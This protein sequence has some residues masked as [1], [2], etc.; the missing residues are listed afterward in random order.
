MP[1][2]LFLCKTHNYG[3][4]ILK[5]IK[6]IF[7][8]R[9]FFLSVSIL[10]ALAVFL[11]FI[12]LCVN[13]ESQTGFYKNPLSFGRILFVIVLI[14]AFAF[15]FVWNKLS[16]RRALLPINMRFDFSSVMSEKLPFAIG[17]I[18]FAVNTFF[19]IYLLSNPLSTLVSV[20]TTNAFAV[21]ATIFST[22]CLVYFMFMTFLIENKFIGKSVFGVVLVAWA[23]F[24]V[25]RDFI[26]SSTV[27]Y[28]SKSLM[29]VLYLC[30]LLLTVFA[31]C[32]LISDTDNFKGY[33]QFSIFAPITIVLGFA[34]SIPAILGWMFG[35]NAVSFSDA[36]MNVVNL[37]L[38][39]FL[40]RFSMHLY[41]EG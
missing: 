25:L 23:V 15:G 36:V 4:V 29:D 7:N 18:G 5:Q 41:K 33:R 20:K 26:T 34:L 24:R 3:D 9:P 38:S 11:R 40:L 30:S 8:R 22:A 21:F 37:A 12:E 6:E 35:V 28:I 17:T 1:A 31:Y 10:S 27:F 16:R 2:Y 19:E 13:I 14:A 39:L 32:R